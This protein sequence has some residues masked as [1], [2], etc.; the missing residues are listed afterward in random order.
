ML[1]GE[2]AIDGADWQIERRTVVNTQIERQFARDF[3]YKRKITRA[4]YELSS[5]KKREDF[6]MWSLEWTIEERFK[7]KLKHVWEKEDVKKTLELY[8]AAEE[9]Y[10]IRWEK[11]Y[12]ELLPM[13]EAIDIVLDSGSGVIYAP[14]AGV[15][16]LYGGEGYICYLLRSERSGKNPAGKERSLPHKR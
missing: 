4:L 1:P 5:P 13:E 8:G 2:K 6:I 15:G 12:D 14:A 16:I 3:F 9:C 10:V 11:E 7:E